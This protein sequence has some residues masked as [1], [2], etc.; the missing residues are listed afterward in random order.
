MTSKVNQGHMRP[1][2]GTFVYGLI[3]M[4]MC[5]NG[6]IIKTQFFH[7]YNFWSNYNL[8]LRSYG[9]LLS[10]FKEYISTYITLIM[11]Y[12]VS[13]GIKF[14]CLARRVQRFI[15]SLHSNSIIFNLKYN[16]KYLHL[17]LFNDYTIYIHNYQPVHRNSNDLCVPKNWF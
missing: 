7:K 6:N 15:P 2:L 8:D 1:L 3:L 9:Q 16:I 10:L 13:T 14:D 17:T 11:N 12:L 4:K 5:M